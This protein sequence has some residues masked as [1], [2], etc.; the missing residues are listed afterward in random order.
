MTSV[1]NSNYLIR[2]RDLIDREILVTPIHVVGA[3]SIGSFTVLTLAKMGFNNINAYDADTVDDA[4]VGCQLYGPKHIGMHKVDALQSIVRDLTG[5]EI[6]FVAGNYLGGKLDGVV[7]A[8]VDS[9]A[10]RRLIFTEQRMNYGMQYYIDPR[11]GAEHAMMYCVKGMNKP[12]FDNYKK[13]LYSDGEAISEPCTAKSTVYTAS[14][15]GS[16][17]AQT[18]KDALMDEAYRHTVQ[19]SIKHYDFEGHAHA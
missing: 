1:D 8:A 5:I 7:I 9:M 10:T 14:Y 6:G 16:L 3:G 4:N 2:S 18:V 15:I 13:T 12:E 19:W 17:V 11:M